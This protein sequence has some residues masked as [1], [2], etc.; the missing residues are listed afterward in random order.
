MQNVVCS[1]EALALLRTGQFQPYAQLDAGLQSQLC[2]GVRLVPLRQGERLTTLGGTQVS[3]LSGKAR[4]SSTG[5]T[6]TDSLTRAKPFMVSTRGD[7]LQAV[8]DAVLALADRDFLDFLSAWHALVRQALETGGLAA[9]RLAQLQRATPFRR[10]PLECVEAAFARMRARQ[11]LAGAEIVR[12]GTPSDSFFTLKTGRAEAWQQGFNGN[13]A[14]KIAELSPGDTF[15]EE[16]LIGGGAHKVT[17]RMVSDGELLELPRTEF[18]DLVAK[19][20]IQEVTPG[21][22][23]SLLDSGWSALDVRYVEEFDESRI[24][25]AQWLPLQALS[26]PAELVLSRAERYV[27]VCGSGKRSAVAAL[28]LAKRGYQV[29]CLKNGLRDSAFELVTTG[30]ASQQD[31]AVA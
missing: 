10:M 27:V 31:K 7:I 1:N 9:E 4:L 22:A 3:V 14:H 18:L 2:D 29:V 23:K 6:L 26:S 5:R 30:Q 20:L 25:N 12:Q 8:D 13:A 15:G 21:A 11:V 17:V 28:L 16:A 24:A 19:P